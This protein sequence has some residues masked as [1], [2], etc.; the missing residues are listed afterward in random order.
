MTGSW[1]TVITKWTTSQSKSRDL[2]PQ[3]GSLRDAP[4]LP[5]NPAIT[6]HHPAIQDGT[7]GSC[8]QGRHKIGTPRD[9]LFGILIHGKR[10][11]RKSNR[12]NEA[13]RVCY[14][15]M[16]LVRRISLPILSK[17]HL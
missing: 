4:I 11:R 3:A 9:I 5:S 16:E 6:E 14:E 13:H 12:Q 1:S 17:R 8:D 15:R 2:N 7:V 10:K